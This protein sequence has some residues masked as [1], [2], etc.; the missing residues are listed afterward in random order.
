MIMVSVQAVW[1]YGFSST[2]VVNY[3]VAA[4]FSFAMVKFKERIINKADSG[5]GNCTSI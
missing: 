3:K 4:F 5:H 1:N 2:D